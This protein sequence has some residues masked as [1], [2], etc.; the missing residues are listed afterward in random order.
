LKSN[1][2]VREFYLGMSDGKRKSFRQV[3]H[4][5]RRKRWL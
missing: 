3:K 5:K 4:Y 2:D 1:E